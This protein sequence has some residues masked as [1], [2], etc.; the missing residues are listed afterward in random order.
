M[1]CYRFRFNDAYPLYYYGH[2]G[3][4]PIPPPIV[5]IILKYAYEM[6]V[7]ENM[8][9]LHD[10][11]DDFLGFLRHF[12]D[13]QKENLRPYE[14]LG[15]QGNVSDKISADSTR[16][17]HDATVNLVT[18]MCPKPRRRR[19]IFTVHT[20]APP[21]PPQIGFVLPEMSSYV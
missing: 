14:I 15:R 12:K 18:A 4:T 5:K 10:R 7:W 17:C 6:T 3:S 11:L 13:N 8:C 1:P 16:L 21:A 9:A 2:G 20:P 19:S